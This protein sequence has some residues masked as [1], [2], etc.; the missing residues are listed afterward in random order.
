MDDLD[1]IGGRYEDK[2]Y[3]NIFQSI[4]TC[5]NIIYKIPVKLTV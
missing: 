4:V 5:G 1:N 3:M 2:I